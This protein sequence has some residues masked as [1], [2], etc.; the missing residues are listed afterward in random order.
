MFFL[1]TWLR[2]LCMNPLCPSLLLMPFKER[3][4]SPTLAG[5]NRIHLPAWGSSVFLCRTQL[6]TWAED[7]QAELLSLCWRGPHCCKSCI[8]YLCLLK[9]SRQKQKK[10]EENWEYPCER[11]LWRAN[12]ISA[13]YGKQ[14]WQVCGSLCTA[15]Y[16]EGV[17]DTMEIFN[18]SES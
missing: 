13:L 10:Q 16:K 15:L 18:Q 11:G 7:D 8:W 2:F 3:N 5:A 17:S 1:Q 14:F 9:D 4:L 12:K 6:S